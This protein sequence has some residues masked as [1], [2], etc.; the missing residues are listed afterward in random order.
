MTNPRFQN[1]SLLHASTQYSLLTLC[2]QAEIKRNFLAP[3][4]LFWNL[5]ISVSLSP[6]PP[7]PP[8]KDSI[9]LFYSLSFLFSSLQRSSSSMIKNPP[10]DQSTMKRLRKCHFQVGR[11]EIRMTNLQS[12]I[13]N[14]QNQRRHCV[15][16]RRRRI[17]CFFFFSRKKF[18]KNFLQYFIL[19]GRRPERE[20]ERRGKFLDSNSSPL[21][22]S[23]SSPLPSFPSRLFLFES[24]RPHPLS[25][26]WFLLWLPLLDQN[27]L[28][29][30]LR[31][32]TTSTWFVFNI[33][34]P[35]FY[36]LEFYSVVPFL[37]F[38][39]L[40]KFGDSSLWP[41]F[42]GLHTPLRP[43]LILF[44]LFTIGGLVL[45][46]LLGVKPFLFWFKILSFWVYFNSFKG[47]PPHHLPHYH[48]HHPHPLMF[49]QKRT[50]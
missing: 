33:P 32:E 28:L 12:P 25:H 22:D 6:P 16:R 13:S 45:L 11:K 40:S 48:R 4:L 17:L 41:V 15:L 43:F 49:S 27:A 8:T 46:S 26:F 14:L 5:F 36:L 35:K 1:H 24:C 3:F 7:L 21:Q 29:F 19:E 44:L 23:R 18:K 30:Y 38:H 47:H 2:Q 34:F 20:R 50:L 37:K 39:N 10:R 31:R 9:S 42:P